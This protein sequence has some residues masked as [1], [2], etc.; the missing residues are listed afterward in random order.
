M[1][2]GTL[3]A[4]LHFQPYHNFTTNVCPLASNSYRN[5]NGDIQISLYWK[6][7]KW[8]VFRLVS[9]ALCHTGSEVLNIFRTSWWMPKP[10]ILSAFSRAWRLCSFSWS[11][12][13]AGDFGHMSRRHPVSL[14]L[15]EHPAF[16][17]GYTYTAT[18]HFSV[19]I[20]TQYLLQQQG[21]S[22]I[23]VSAR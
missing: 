10:K 13:W 4:T 7:L 20:K 23:P 14:R 15:P 3:S 16:R 12:G 22:R 1:R 2:T 11:S 21:L 6:K 5:I 9:L 19:L 8:K 17:L 18:N